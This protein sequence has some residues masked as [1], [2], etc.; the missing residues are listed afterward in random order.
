MTK[1]RIMGIYGILCEANQR[2]YV[3]ASVNIHQRFYEHLAKAKIS[4]RHS[5]M[6]D[7]MRE[8][9]EDAFTTHILERI[10]DGADLPERE[11]FWQNITES[12]THGYNAQM[13]G[14]H[15]SW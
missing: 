13:G 1:P 11:R 9:G 2:W 12:K 3:G 15:R 4:A 5:H 10:S 6:F 14:K 8:H 7:D